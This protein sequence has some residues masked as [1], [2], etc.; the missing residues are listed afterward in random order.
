MW[1]YKNPSFPIDNKTEC[2]KLDKTDGAK[3]A[4]MF[5]EIKESLASEKMVLFTHS[6][7]LSCEALV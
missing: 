4:V 1:V 2:L 7:N 3:S 6:D 5:T